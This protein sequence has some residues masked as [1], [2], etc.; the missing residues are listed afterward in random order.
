MYFNFQYTLCVKSDNP[1]CFLKLMTGYEIR[2]YG[3]R[4]SRFS[5]VDIGVDQVKNKMERAAYCDVED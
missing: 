2:D 4:L 1:H 5:L 3:K